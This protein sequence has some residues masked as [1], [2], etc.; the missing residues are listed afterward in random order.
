MPLREVIWQ[1]K[2]AGLGSI[3]GGGG[4]QPSTKGWMVQRS[5][6][7]CCVWPTFS[8]KRSRI[9]WH[10]LSFRSFA[11]ARKASLFSPLRMSSSVSPAAAPADQYSAAATLYHA[12]GKV[13]H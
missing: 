6:R 8:S 1:F 7:P 5:V 3:P 10:H 11:R 13:L 12:A 2:E 4:S 9:F